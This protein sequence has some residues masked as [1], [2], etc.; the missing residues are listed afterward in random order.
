M[1]ELEKAVAQS[2]Q[3]IVEKVAAMHRAE[4]VVQFT[5]DE[6]LVGLQWAFH[7]FRHGVDVQK[8][9][10][11]SQ[12]PDLVEGA[13]MSELIELFTLCTTLAPQDTPQVQ[14]C[15]AVGVSFAVRML[16]SQSLQ[17]VFNMV[18]NVFGRIAAAANQAWTELILNVLKHMDETAVQL[19]V[20]HYNNSA[21]ILSGT[22]TILL[23]RLMGFV[24]SVY[25]YSVNRYWPVFQ[26]Y[27][28][29]SD[30]DLRVAALHELRYFVNSGG[31]AFFQAAV[32]PSLFDFAVS[33]DPVVASE[34]FR[35]LVEVSKSVSPTFREKVLSPILL[36]YISDCVPSDT[37]AVVL[38]EFGPMTLSVCDGK[39]KP[40]TALLRHYQQAAVAQKADD[41]RISCAYNFPAMFQ[42]FGPSDASG[43]LATLE[44]LVKDPCVEVRRRCAA[45]F[46]EVCAMLGERC[47]VLASGIFLT[48]MSDADATVRSKVVA[49]INS[50]IPLMHSQCTESTRNA[51]MSTVLM[52]LVQ[53]ENLV[54]SEWRKVA[55]I[56]SH[57]GKLASYY[58]V[59]EQH[60]SMIPILLKHLRNGAMALKPT[61][62][63]IIVQTLQTACAGD[64][65]GLAESLL[66]SVLELGTSD[67][68]THRQ[69]FV[70]AATAFSREFG[71]TVMDAYFIPVLAR[72][73]VDPVDNVRRKVAIAACGLH[74]TQQVVSMRSALMMDSSK[75]VS[76]AARFGGESGKPCLK[77]PSPHDAFLAALTPKIHKTK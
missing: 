53:Y 59:T 33:D 15:Y 42:I 76:N 23:L 13:T 54:T 36:G 50:I 38:H 70:D 6:G 63:A 2:S 16:D 8:V 28:H 48:L 61:C 66:T 72:L 1:A 67:S 44:A 58:S 55:I 41:V 71:P 45:G 52:L 73:S 49:N 29:S 4:D 62:A 24:V 68:C 37:Q 57:L 17:S 51:F 40:H 77:S 19:L 34:F 14:E 56:L 3:D 35:F 39:A 9:C 30:L 11:A 60:N 22:S 47:Y 10:A 64:H 18:V 43:V 31:T 32:F 26:K 74:S 27:L 21:A 5:H 69:S 46:H 12:L 7:I 65:R 75:E 20:G 25:P